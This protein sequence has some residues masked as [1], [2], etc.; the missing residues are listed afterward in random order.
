MHACVLP[1]L[2]ATL[3]HLQA[4]LSAVQG[5]WPF[6]AAVTCCTQAYGSICVFMLCIL[7]CQCAM[8]PV[9]PCVSAAPLPDTHLSIPPPCRGQSGA[10][11]T[12]SGRTTATM[13]VCCQTS[14]A[15]GPQAG[16]AAGKHPT[17][18]TSS[19]SRLGQQ[20]RGV[21]LH[22]QQQLHV[23]PCAAR[24]GTPG[25]CCWL[26][27]QVLPLCHPWTHTQ[28]RCVIATHAG[29][30]LMISNMVIP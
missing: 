26:P 11:C 15:A 27:A 18:A 7:L 12:T 13:S 1:A 28:L 5:I 29:L 3:G 25:E 8:P 16:T 20:H 9:F 4:L 19:T 21:P 23:W 30:L 6:I 14:H 24:P 10:T 17:A 22:L 2:P